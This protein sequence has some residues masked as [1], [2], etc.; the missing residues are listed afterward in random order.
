MNYPPPEPTHAPLAPRGGQ[1]ADRSAE[2]V[3]AAAAHGAIAFGLFGIGLLVSLLISGVIWLYSRR[4]P[5]VRF[6]S[7]QAG[8]YQCSVLLINVA[9]LLIF[10]S[11]GIFSVFQ[12]FQGREDWGTSWVALIAVVLGLIWFVGTIV[13]GIIGAVMVLLGRPFKYVIIGDR[14]SRNADIV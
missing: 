12:A 11:S 6:H 2:R 8:C 5:H 3:L 1:A 4:S 14:F 9:L 10:L 7:E 13:Y